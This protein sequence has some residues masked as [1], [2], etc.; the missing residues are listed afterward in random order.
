MAAFK[1][2]RIQTVDFTV[3]IDK[4][5]TSNRSN[6]LSPQEPGNAE[7]QLP[8]ASFRF[9]SSPLE[10]ENY[11]GAPKLMAA[12]YGR[13]PCSHVKA[14]CKLIDAGRT[15]TD[16]E[17]SGHHPDRRKVAGSIRKSWP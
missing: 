7:R 9:Q 5:C 16:R 8:I 3:P 10:S 1:Q 4:W 14:M 15:E 12:A 2:N 17:L 13:N 11:L 6:L